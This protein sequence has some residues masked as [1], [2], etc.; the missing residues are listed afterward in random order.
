MSRTLSKV[1]ALTGGIGSGLDVVAS[2]F[3]GA[4]VPVV[5]ADSL[6]EATFEEQLVSLFGK[7]DKVAA[8]ATLMTSPREVQ[9]E[10]VTKMKEALLLRT[11]EELRAKLTEGHSLVCL[12]SAYLIEG[13]NH[14]RFRPLVVVVAPYERQ[15]LNV[16]MAGGFSEEEARSRIQSQVPQTRKILLA[17]YLLDHKGTEE[18]LRA[19]ASWILSHLRETSA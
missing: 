12:L 18:E 11:G 7:T 19:E 5:D 13:G 15:L 1:F 3:V 6:V 10:F 14:E 2:V 8:M 17:D 4:G 16:T 9:E